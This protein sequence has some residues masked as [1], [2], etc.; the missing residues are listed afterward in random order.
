MLRV[1]AN[2]DASIDSQRSE[3]AHKAHRE[4]L[5]ASWKA[6]LPLIVDAGL[7]LSGP[8]DGADS[9]FGGI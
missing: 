9:D 8:E 3:S 5:I 2:R 4:Q 1:E 7:A 6:H